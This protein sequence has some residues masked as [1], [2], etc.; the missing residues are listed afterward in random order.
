MENNLKATSKLQHNFLPSAVFPC[1]KPTTITCNARTIG[2]ATC[3]YQQC[4][5]LTSVDSDEPVQSPFKLRNN[6]CCS[7]SSLTIIEYPNDKQ[8]LWSDCAYAQLDL[9]LWWSHIPHCWE[10]HVAAHM[11]TI[12]ETALPVYNILLNHALTSLFTYH[13]IAEHLV[14]Q[15]AN[16]VLG[17]VSIQT[18]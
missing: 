12:S 13:P 18:L 5:I 9:S 2:A 6:K 16:K 7:V 15:C 8:K 10:S 4:G 17:M 1:A 3:D 11:Y 14:K